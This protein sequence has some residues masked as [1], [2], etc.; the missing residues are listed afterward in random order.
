MLKSFITKLIKFILPITFVLL[1]PLLI[2]FYFCENFNNIDDI[3][4]LENEVLIGYKYNE[5]NYKYLKWKSIESKKKKDIIAIGSSRVLGLREELFSEKFYN[6]G[7][8][9]INASDYLSFLKS[10]PNDKKPKLLI[11]GLDQWIFNEN[12]SKNKLNKKINYWQNS[13]RFYPSLQNI[14]SVYSDFGS[15]FSFLNKKS[16]KI[17]NTTYIGLRAYIDNIGFRKDG[18]MNYHGLVNRL[19]N[20]DSTLKQ[21]NFND[22]KSRIN[23]G[24]RK[25]QFANSTD[26]YAIIE[27]QKL[28]KYCSSNNIKVIGFLPPFP[29]EILDIM[30]NNNNYNYLNLIYKNLHPSFNKYGFEL[31]DFT[32][33]KII[34]SNDSEFIDGFHGGELTYLKMIKFMTENNSLISDFVNHN[35][36]TLLTINSKNNFVIK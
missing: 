15:I 7:Y 9:V 17:K 35:N 2:L 20:N 34:N 8:T 31:W 18:S 4:A 32:D 5:S 33:P 10:I 28:L 36:L 16:K 29:K 14:I 22:T 12:W 30:I 6:A 25:F 11:L 3:I 27:I 23:Q 26:K 1:L 24:N 19:I 21:Y 13:F